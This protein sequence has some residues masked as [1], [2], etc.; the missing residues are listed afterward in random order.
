M[1][2]LQIINCNFNIMRLN[3]KKGKVYG[4]LTVLGEGKKVIQPS[5]Q[6]VRTIKCKCKCGTVKDIRLAHLVRGHTKSCGCII[7]TKNGKSKTK[8]GRL[9]NG[10]KSRCSINHSESHLYYE[11]GITVCDEWLNDIDKF[12]KWCNENGYKEGLQIDRIDGDQGYFPLNCRFVT[13]KVNC[14]NRH[15]TMYVIYKGKKESLQL[16]LHRLNYPNKYYTV[17]MRIIRGWNIYDAIHKN[18]ATN[19]LSRKKN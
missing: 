1:F 15:N 2:I 18:P 13:S 9:L 7:K 14:N 5:K 6:K 8:I 17:R 3:I 10:M 12:E 4:R 16:L 19:Y 11:K